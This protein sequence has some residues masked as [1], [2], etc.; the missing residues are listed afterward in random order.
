[1]KIKIEAMTI[2]DSKSVA[3]IHTK[4]WQFAYKGIVPQEFLD[5]I[6]TKKREENWTKGMIEDPSLIRLVA[7]DD[8][9]NILGFVCGL[10]NREKNIQIDSELWA[11][12]VHPEKIK[13]GIGKLLFSSFIDKLRIKNFSTMNVWVL[14]KNNNARSFYE[15]MGGALSKYKKEI[16]I[17]GEKLMEVSY[18]YQ[19]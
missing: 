19:I 4:S 13:H 9:N 14:E 18:E 6:D 15:K 1:M 8:N 12:Y 10:H 5:G 2:N 11:I 3:E 17:G 16:E 7:K